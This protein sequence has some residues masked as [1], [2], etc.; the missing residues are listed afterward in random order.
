MGI[1]LWG[2]RFAVAASGV[3]VAGCSVFSLSA[4]A[5]PAPTAA[6]AQA[7]MPQDDSD[8]SAITRVLRLQHQEVIEANRRAQTK[9]EEQDRALAA[10]QALSEHQRRLETMKGGDTLN[11][12]AGH[13]NGVKNERARTAGDLLTGTRTGGDSEPA[14]GDGSVD[15]GTCA[16]CSSAESYPDLR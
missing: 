16:G 9:A 2:R 14:N 1:S 5:A 3:L 7:A 13:D 8:R 10:R 12:L 15:Y 6:A 11:G 4:W